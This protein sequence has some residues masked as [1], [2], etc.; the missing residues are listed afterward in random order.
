MRG[1]VLPNID[2]GDLDQLL[3]GGELMVMPA[4]F[5]AQFDQTKLRVFCHKHALYTLP[6]VELIA[7]LRE[8]IGGRSAIEIGAGQGAIGR[9][10]GIPRTDSYMQQRPEVAQLYRMT[11]QPT[12]TYPKDVEKL[13]AI[14]ALRKYRPQ[15]V[16]GSW[17]TQ[18]YMEGPAY[19]QNASVYGPDE[20]QILARCEEYI[21]IGNEAPHGDK[22]ILDRL[23]EKHRL[24]FLYSRAQTPEL[25]IVYIFRG[26]KATDEKGR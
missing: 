9:A 17:I 12:V 19:R 4:T 24:P 1:Q 26:D 3:K 18:K 7:W 8:R 11:G 20:Q 5:Y 10:L 25:N 13:D 6:T 2:T 23:A 21:H 14:K 16:I 15:V 22:R